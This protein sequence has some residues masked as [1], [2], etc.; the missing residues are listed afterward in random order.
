MKVR[1]IL[2]YVIHVSSGVAGFV[3]AYWVGYFHQSFHDELIVIIPVLLVMDVFIGS[4]D[5]LRPVITSVFFE[6]HEG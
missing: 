4:G 5:E 6:I 1:V 2:G 3:A